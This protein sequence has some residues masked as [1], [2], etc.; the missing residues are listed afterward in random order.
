M[1]SHIEADRYRCFSQMKIDVAPYNVL[2]G[3]NGSGK[4]TLID[5]PL[6]V[7]DMLRRGPVSAFLESESPL[8]SPR[9]Q[10]LLQLV[11]CGLGN[12]FGLV[13][14]AD[15]PESVVIQL[16]EQMAPSAK[17][18]RQLW[19]RRIRYEVRFEVY[20]RVDLQ[21]LEEFL[22]LVPGQRDEPPETGIGGIR[23]Q[24]WKPLVGRSSGDPVTVQPEVISRPQRL[25]L[26]PQDLALAN[27]PRDIRLFPSVMWFTNML[28]R[29]ALYYSPNLQ[30]LRKASPPG[31]TRRLKSDASNL[32]WMA[33]AL[34]KDQ[35]DV[36]ADWVAHVRTALP[37]V[38]AI[39]AKEREEDHHAYLQVTYQGNYQVTSSGLSDGTLRI[40]AY[41]ILPYLPTP[42]EVICIEE[43]EDG[44]HPRAIE[45]IL[46]S[47]RSLYDTQVW[48]TTQSPTVL[49]QTDLDDTIMMRRNDDGSVE[50]MRGPDHP[51]LQDWKDAVDLGTLF[52][53][54]V[55]E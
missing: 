35:S 36:F 38:T 28:E 45:S 55:L 41:T 13:I 5:I 44:I 17:R 34:Q 14:E 37:H 50:A 12:Y 51:R 6:L 10:E 29:N 1:I 27:I 46:N 53:A 16:V 23:P 52:A 22:W 49:A 48:L 21:V 26:E 2:A 33:L 39:V 19:P 42:P 54:G 7:G 9:A 32:P 30:L 43:P 40:L 15:L 18:K 24:T 47:L 8:Q 20:N 11:H 3:A 31:Q 4:S 25:V